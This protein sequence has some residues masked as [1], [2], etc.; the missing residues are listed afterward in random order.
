[1][2]SMVRFGDIWPYDYLVERQV[3]LEFELP[4]MARFGQPQS[5]RLAFGEPSS[6]LGGLGQISAY[7]S[8]TTPTPS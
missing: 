5:V 2:V 6:C 7:G 3:V 4:V 8:E 1:M